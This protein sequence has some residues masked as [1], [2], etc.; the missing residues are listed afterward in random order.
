MSGPRLGLL[1]QLLASLVL[2][3]LLAR[4]VPLEDVRAALAR[5]RPG[6]LVPCLALTLVAYL[7]RSLRWRGLLRRIGIAMTVGTTYRL[8]LVGTFYGLITPGRLGEFARILHVSA[9]RSETLPSVIWDRIADVILLEILCVPAFVWVPA[10]RGTLLLVYL[11]LVLATI[12]G[13]ALLANPALY[14]AATR[15]LPN[16]TA[17]IRRWSE[18]SQDLARGGASP[19]SFGWGV[20]FYLFTAPAAWLLMRELAPGTPPL[21]LLGLPLLPLLG[22]IPIAIGGLGLREQV[23]AAVFQGLGAGAAEGVVFSLLWFTVVTL[24]PGLAGLALSALSAARRAG[25]ARERA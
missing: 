14:R 4:N 8:T 13:V 10:W 24:L 23:S 22:N 9:P 11:A 3:A 5:L 19:A 21:L 2:L 12:V 20:F 1:L 18:N 6:T 15:L 16:L 7:G 17:P 25:R